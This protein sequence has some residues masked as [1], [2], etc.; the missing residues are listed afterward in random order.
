MRLEVVNLPEA[1]SFLAN[2]APQALWQG[3]YDG[4]QAS[5]KDVEQDI[6]ARMPVKSGKSRASVFSRMAGA[7]SAEAGVTLGEA[8]YFRTL[9]FGAKA[10]PIFAKGRIGSKASKALARHARRHNF[11]LAWERG[12]NDTNWLQLGRSSTLKKA[13]LL[14]NGGLR[15][16][17]MHPGVRPQFF[18]AQ[19]LT[20]CEGRIV[21]TIS[22]AITRR[23]DEAAH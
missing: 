9:V 6:S 12:F 1:M 11:D 16:M 19:S 8:W 23:L 15:A 10:H 20:N 18:P 7:L 14:P 21:T 13:L 17:V 4:L 3:M 22:D 5:I 2:Q